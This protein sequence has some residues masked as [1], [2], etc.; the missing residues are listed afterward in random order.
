MICILICGKQGSG[1]TTLA[2]EITFKE[3]VVL[4]LKFAEPL[5]KIH[6]A[7]R[8]I[9]A[10]YGVDD[11]VGIDGPLLQLLGTEWGRKTRDM[12]IWVNCAKNKVKNLSALTPDCVA[13]FDDCR[14]ENEFYALDK[15]AR[16]F[17]LRLHADRDVRKLRAAKWREN[18]LHES[19]TGLDHL[20]DSL[21]DLVIDTSHTDTRE[22]VELVTESLKEKFACG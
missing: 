14:F 18:E 6:D 16:V 21:F 1:K 22:V 17:K 12:D 8:S 19:E 13:I 20:D 11:K 10:A 4:S 5:Y 7:A 15:I 2:S 9:L 3:K